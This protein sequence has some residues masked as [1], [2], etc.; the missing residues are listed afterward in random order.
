MHRHQFTEKLSRAKCW[1][2]DSTQDSLREESRE[3]SDNILSLY[4]A[5]Q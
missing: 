4:N 3:S 2:P 1:L 5:I